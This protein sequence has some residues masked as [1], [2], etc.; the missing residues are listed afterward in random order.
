MARGDVFFEGELTSNVTSFRAHGQ[1][2][3]DLAARTVAPPPRVEIGGVE[4]TWYEL[5]DAEKVAYMDGYIAGAATLKRLEDEGVSLSDNP[6]IEDW[7][8]PVAAAGPG[9]PEV[10]AARL[11]GRMRAF[12]CEGARQAALAGD[13]PSVRVAHSAFQGGSVVAHELRPV[14]DGNRY[15]FVGDIAKGDSRRGT[16]EVMVHMDEFLGRD[17]EA[18]AA[19]RRATH[20]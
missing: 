3:D 9:G 15:A 17:H 13:R 5:S 18:E 2:D 4:R 10:A 1:D 6:A 12:G 19:H 14:I 8:G 16:S 7:V 11:A 20:S